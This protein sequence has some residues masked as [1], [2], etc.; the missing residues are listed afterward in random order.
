MD[1]YVEIVR[2]VE[3]TILTLSFIIIVTF[4][5]YVY[6]NNFNK[7]K[8]EIKVGPIEIASA[9]TLPVLLAIIFVGYTYVSLSHPFEW[10]R[11][12]WKRD[13]ENVSYS[14]VQFRGFEAAGLTRTFTSVA[15][16]AEDLQRS[17]IAKMQEILRLSL[18]AEELM[19]TS[20]AEEVDRLLNTDHPFDELRKSINQIYD[21][22]EQ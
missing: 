17:D 1:T 21:E 12:E 22:L 13:M 8:A 9:I 6:R 11:I 2:L 15:R 20:R 10:K 18:K 16:Q 19:G 4:L 14:N 7:Q 3:R 5:V